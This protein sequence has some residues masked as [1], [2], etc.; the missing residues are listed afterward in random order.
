MPKY[1]SDYSLM[2]LYTPGST[3]Y[4]N[5]FHQGRHLTLTIYIVGYPNVIEWDS[6]PGGGR[7]VPVRL[8][9]N[10]TLLLYTVHTWLRLHGKHTTARSRYQHQQSTSRL[11]LICQNYIVNSHDRDF[12]AVAR[13]G[14]VFL[15]RS[16]NSVPS[17]HN[18][19][20]ICF[21]LDGNSPAS[22]PGKKSHF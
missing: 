5:D 2:E 12:R 15:G 22:T 13:W 3:L 11:V 8:L 21:F 20:N 9:L 4:P 19:S 16:K 6:F 1:L 10:G 18:I 7:R 14:R 17:H